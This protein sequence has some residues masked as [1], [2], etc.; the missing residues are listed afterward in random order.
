M[1]YKYIIIYIYYIYN[2]L[3]YIIILYV[4]L[5]LIRWSLKSTDWRGERNETA[6][7]KRRVTFNYENVPLGNAFLA[8]SDTAKISVDFNLPRSIM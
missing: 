4:I 2:I 8:F 6:G 1:L 7:G 3:L 5:L